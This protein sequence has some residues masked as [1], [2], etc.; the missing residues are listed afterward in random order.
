MKRALEYGAFLLIGALIMAASLASTSYVAGLP[1]GWYPV[2]IYTE[3]DETP[4]GQGQIFT[5]EG[6]VVENR[7]YFVRVPDE[8]VLYFDPQNPDKTACVHPRGAPAEVTSD[9]V[10]GRAVAEN[11]QRDPIG[12]LWRSPSGGTLSTEVQKK[13]Y[14]SRYLP[15]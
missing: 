1:G 12:R 2:G 15:R 11:S 7:C 14:E 13:A 4:A 6:D 3:P 5:A 10:P 9:A 8:G